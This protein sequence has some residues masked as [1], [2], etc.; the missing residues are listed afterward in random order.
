LLTVNTRLFM[1]KFIAIVCSGALTTGAFA[2]GTVNFLNNPNTLVS[3]GTAS[4]STPISGPMGSWYF[5]LLTSPVGSNTFTFSGT[6]ATNY[7][8]AGTEGRFNGGSIV[9]VAG[10]APKASRDVE[11][12]GWSSDLGPVFNSAW[13]TSEPTSG[14]FGISFP[15]TMQAGGFDGTNMWPTTGMFGGATG[16]QTGFVLLSALP[17]PQ[18]TIVHAGTNVVLAWSTNYAGFSLQVNTDLGSSVWTTNSSIP[19]GVNGKNTVTNPV[20]GSQEF[21][22]LAQSNVYS[23]N[24]VGYAT[25]NVPPGY[26]LLANPLS[27]GQRN[28]ADEIGL[29][30]SGNQILIWNGSGYDSFYYDLSFGGWVNQSF[31]PTIPPSLPPGRG[32]FLFNP[33]PTATNI[34][35]IGEVLPAPSS[36]NT[37]SLPSGFAL[38]GS[39][40]PANVTNIALPPISLPLFASMQVLTWSGSGFVYSSYDPSF[41]GWVDADFKPKPPPSYEI[42]QAFFFF[43]P[44]DGAWRQSLP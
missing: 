18:L 26:S 7:G 16:I 5:A 29:Q 3:S 27:T 25:V 36:T 12:A 31:A 2:Q 42:G 6:Y 38:L 33:L 20:S 41:G 24:I 1:K 34:T 11:V 10:W 22:R 44:G 30:I 8:G 32:F 37:L 19:A 40:L 43:N 23:P 14:F 21:F 9:P 28:G 35:F 15:G 4:S 39:P 13:L 17:K